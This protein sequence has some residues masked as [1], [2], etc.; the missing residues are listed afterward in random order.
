MTPEVDIVGVLAA[1]GLGAAGT[2]IF[3]GPVRDQKDVIPDAAIFAMQTG[4]VVTPFFGGPNG[5]DEHDGRV[6]VNVRSAK[7]DY[8][9]GR[10]TAAA[11]RDALHKQAP[12]GY[13]GWWADEPTY[14]ET[15]QKKRSRW[16]VN[17]RVLYDE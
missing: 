12:V 11:V 5:E 14:I 9:T 7:D 3:E 16:S 6:Q 13:A 2:D 10:A 8:E 15:D 4:G 1:A 17:I